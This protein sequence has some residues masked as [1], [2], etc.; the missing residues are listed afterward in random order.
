MS[1]T[2]ERTGDG[3]DSAL[4]S[5]DDEDGVGGNGRQGEG[6]AGLDEVPPATFPEDGRSSLKLR[7]DASVKSPPFTQIFMETGGQIESMAL[8]WE[9]DMS[10]TGSKTSTVVRFK[11]V[12]TVPVSIDVPL[13]RV[14]FDIEGKARIPP[15]MRINV[16][17]QRMAA[18]INGTLA[19]SLSGE[20][21]D[22]LFNALSAHGH[23]QMGQHYK[24]FRSFS[25]VM[26]IS[27]VRLVMVDTDGDE[28]RVQWKLK[29]ADDETSKKLQAAAKLVEEYVRAGYA[30]RQALV[31]KPAPMLHK[32]V[33]SEV[34]GID[35]QGYNLLHN[36]TNR[37]AY[38][39]LETLNKLYEM[40]V[41]CELSQDS[42]EI[43]KFLSFTDRPGLVAAMNAGTIA[44]ATSL[45]V[46]ILMSY[47]ADGVN[48]VTPNGSGFAPVENWNASVP[49]SALEVNDCDGLTMLAIALIK[50]TLKLTPEQLGNKEYKYLRAVR[51]AIFPHYQLALSVIGASAA[52][53]TSADETHAAV[54]GHAIT[55][56]VPTMSFLRALSKTTE[57]RAGKDGPF[58]CPP[59]LVNAV[60]DARFAALYPLS[61]RDEL[62]SNENDLLANWGTAQHEFTQL[63]AFAIEGT[64]PASSNLYLVN[65]ERR[66]SARKQAELDK[67]VFASASPNV[68]RSIKVMHVGGSSAASTHTFYSELV[69]LTFDNEFPLYVSAE[70]RQMGLAAS[71]FVLTPVSREDEITEAGV[72]PQKLV[73]EEYGAVPLVKLNTIASTVLDD[74]SRVAKLDIVPPREVGP[75]QLDEFQS[76]SLEKSMRHVNDLQ[77]FL[78]ELAKKNEIGENH[79]C[80]AYICAFNTLVHNP[81]AVEEFLKTVKTVAVSGVVD[82]KVIPGL[83]TNHKG[84]DVGVFVHVDIY[85]PV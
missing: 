53:A 31:Y 29:K 2:D 8:R 81:D 18:A 56:L 10:L 46:N 3:A 23:Y 72:S 79:H 67:K 26:A 35:S 21:S 60:N 11:E 1:E 50:S 62:P 28:T 63:K 9:S 5:S 44:S 55:V 65:P 38:L 51:N 27:N 14:L 16:M 80:V 20:S 75:T 33:Y 69:E 19:T 85:A 42:R 71:Q 22:H 54:A 64:T 6:R 34:V 24:S 82:M 40:A 39:S 58:V 30:M 78:S 43:N 61:T 17:T 57:K 77:A 70:L 4:L 32:T 45:I 66:E 41:S 68:F 83:A 25:A 7:F 13:D 52:E 84:E 73:M 47:R 74:A 36:I 59:H 49:R 15:D 12:E 48:I 37:E 76:E